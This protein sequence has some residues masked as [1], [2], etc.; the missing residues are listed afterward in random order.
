[1][2][3]LISLQIIA[4]HRSAMIEHNSARL[5]GERSFVRVNVDEAFDRLDV[6]MRSGSA[7]GD[8]AAPRWIGSVGAARALDLYRSMIERLFAHIAIGLCGV[9]IARLMLTQRVGV[10]AH[11]V[12]RFLLVLI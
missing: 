9:L 2:R 11:V 3:T 12:S 1:M 6:I 5:I 8:R 10:S 7:V 4:V